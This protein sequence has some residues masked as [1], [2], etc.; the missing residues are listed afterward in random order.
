MLE[1]ALGYNNKDSSVP[2]EFTKEELKEKYPLFMQWDKRWGYVSYGDSCIGL[3]GCAPTCLSMAILALTD[4]KDATP[5][6][7]AIYA[8]DAGFYMKGSGTSWSFMTEGA[9]HFGING[10]EICLSQGTVFSEIQSGHPIICSMG[11]GDFTTQGHFIVLV[12]EQDGKIIVNDP[13]SRER[14]SVLWDYDVLQ[15]QIKNLW[16]YSR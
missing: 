13:N 4:N 9:S 12:G 14:S 7:V 15:G 3:A 5:D 8:Q 11:P 1:F 10:K 16:A 6:R 2:C